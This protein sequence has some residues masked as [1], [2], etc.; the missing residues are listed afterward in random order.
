MSAIASFTF[1]NNRSE[2]YSQYFFQSLRALGLQLW[3]LLYF[4]QLPTL[5]MIIY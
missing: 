1:A 4:V 2:I 5:L 3:L